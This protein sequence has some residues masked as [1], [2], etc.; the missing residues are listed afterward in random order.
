M[1]NVSRYLPVLVF[2]FSSVQITF[3]QKESNKSAGVH[4]KEP[5]PLYATFPKQVEET[6]GLIWYDG[7][8][9]SFNDSGGKPEIYKI[10][11]LGN[12]IQTVHLA[13]TKNHDWEDITQDKDHIYVGDF[14]NNLGNRENLWIYKINKSALK[15]DKSMEVSATGLTFVYADQTDFSIRNRK[16][17][18]DCEA[19]ISFGDSLLLFSKNWVDG[20][21]RMYKVAKIRGRYPVEPVFTFNAD[22]LVTGASY[23][24]KNK[25]LAL[26]GYKNLVPFIWLIENFDG[27]SI[28]TENA[29]RFDLVSLTN[30]QTEGIC[31]SDENTLIISTEKRDEFQQGA[32]I[33]KLPFL[34]EAAK[35]AKK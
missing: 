15:D 26:I 35:T 9:W 27:Q 32:Y 16:H 23:C 19:M 21:T 25:I 11:S 24:Q 20:K 34:L 14:G 6:S 2:L 33:L 22:G 7:S 29:T 18:H 17:D 13:K 12:I 5:V 8:I 10:D 1:M 3:A 28:N 31:W 30:A 4:I